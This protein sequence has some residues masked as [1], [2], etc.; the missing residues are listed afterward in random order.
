V[1][2][3]VKY[4]VQRSLQATIDT[5]ALLRRSNKPNVTGVRLRMPSEPHWWSLLQLMQPS[6]LRAAHSMARRLLRLVAIPS[7]QIL[8]VVTFP[9]AP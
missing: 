5:Q 9:I 2:L 7:P 8:F 3:Q 6:Q 1:H 4:T